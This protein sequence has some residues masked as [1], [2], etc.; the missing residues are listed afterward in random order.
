MSEPTI[1]ELQAQVRRLTLKLE[2]M[3]IAAK[4]VLPILE[5]A[6]YEQSVPALRA[7]IEKCRPEA[8]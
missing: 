5:H 1:Q 2:C 8:P 7:L 4:T 6:D 3:I